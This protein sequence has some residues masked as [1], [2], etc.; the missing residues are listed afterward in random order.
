MRKM[1]TNKAMKIATAAPM[2]MRSLLRAVYTSQGDHGVG[3][4]SK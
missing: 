2:C 3:A 4:I 1:L